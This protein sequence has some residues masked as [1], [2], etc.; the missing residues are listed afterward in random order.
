MRIAIIS[1]IHSNLSALKN[2]LKDMEQIGYDTVVCLGDIVGYGP[3]PAECIEIIRKSNI[4][5]IMGNHD[6]AVCGDLDAE[7]FNSYAKRAIEWTKKTLNLTDIA[8]LKNLKP[9]IAEENRLYIHGALNEPF[10]YILNRNSLEKNIN[11]LQNDFSGINI[12][13]FGHTHNSF[14]SIN[15]TF[16]M[17]TTG[18][19]SISH[20]EKD[21]VFINPGSVGQPRGGHSNGAAYCMFNTVTGEIHFRTVK[22]DIKETYSRILEKGLPKFLGLRLFNGV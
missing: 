18:R 13:F 4:E 11:I 17:N 10:D 19:Y 9:R 15:G 20:P 6:A 3:D 16:E 7:L 5:C 14:V 8:F 22:Y 1:D 21:V 2:V 12:C